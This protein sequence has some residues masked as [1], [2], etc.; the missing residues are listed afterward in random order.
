MQSKTYL[1]R[2]QDSV[3]RRFKKR[4]ILKRSLSK[5]DGR[6]KKGGG[7]RSRVMTNGSVFEKA[8]NWI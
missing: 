6:G 5:I 3:F 1:I 4:K 7:G 8:G 2:L